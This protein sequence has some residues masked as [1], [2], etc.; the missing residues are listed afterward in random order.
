ML[1]VMFLVSEVFLF[2]TLRQK[3]ALDVLYQNEK[4]QV[5]QLQAQLDQLKISNTDAQN[6]EIARLRAENQDLPRLRSRV[7][8]LEATNAIIFRQLRATANY[9]RQQQS[10]LQQLVEAQQAQAQEAERMACIN[11]LRQIDAAKQQWA[12]DRGRTATALPTIEDLLPYLKDG[13]FPVCP[14][15]GTYSI[16]VVGQ[17]PTCTVPGHVLPASQ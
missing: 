1:I 14:S 7:N 10:Q 16:N 3:A 4:Q 9:A 12:L 2:A 17:L 15:G 8:Q 11:N 13:V 5:D 6:A